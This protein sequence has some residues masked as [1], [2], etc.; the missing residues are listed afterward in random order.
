KPGSRCADI[1]TSRSAAEISREIVALVVL[2]SLGC[3]I[4][5]MDP[6]HHLTAGVSSRVERKRI[7][8]CWRRKWKF[9]TDNA[10]N[11]LLEDFV[12]ARQRRIQKTLIMAAISKYELPVEL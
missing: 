12:H 9:G 10:S 5:A 6:R 7:S 8:L 2:P 4:I 1:A 3:G 11:V